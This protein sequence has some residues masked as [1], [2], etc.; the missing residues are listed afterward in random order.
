MPTNNT[1]AAV[2]AV[3]LQDGLTTVTA[4]QL[5]NGALVI[6][7]DD[8]SIVLHRKGLLNLK[9]LLATLNLED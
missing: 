2:S 3:T 7:Q 6:A 4:T 9:R 8:E 1:I 5:S